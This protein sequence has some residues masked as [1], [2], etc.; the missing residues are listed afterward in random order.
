MVDEMTPEGLT[1]KVAKL[2]AA[3]ADLSAKNAMQLNFIGGVK[4][5]QGGVGSFSS[6]E[7][8]GFFEHYLEA[9]PQE[10]RQRTLSDNNP[11][12]FDASDTRAVRKLVDSDRSS[13]LTSGFN[14]PEPAWCFLF[15]ASASV[16]ELLKSTM[17]LLEKKRSTPREDVQ[18]GET[19]SPEDQHID[20]I[21]E[22]LSVA[23]NIRSPYDY[24]VWRGD[25]IRRRWRMGN[26]VTPDDHEQLQHLEIQLCWLMNCLARINPHTQESAEDFESKAATATLN[27]AAKMEGQPCVPIQ[28]YTGGGAK[29]GGAKGGKNGSKGG[30]R[31]GKGGGKGN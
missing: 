28:S 24:C 22:S 27:Q 18:P 7:K 4:S 3:V 2:A 20:K 21:C 13:G 6:S 17:C 8:E 23:E 16:K 30:S 25:Y 29:G 11:Q 19:V 10:D 14:V 15:D 12:L 26:A 9:N 5:G 31:D 1:A